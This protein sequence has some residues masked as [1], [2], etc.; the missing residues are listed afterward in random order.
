MS[1][2]WDI[3][4]TLAGHVPA[5][6]RDI[7]DISLKE[8]PNVPLGGSLEGRSRLGHDLRTKSL[9]AWRAQRA[10]KLALDNLSKREVTSPEVAR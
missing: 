3:S 6:D 7:W 4:G 8:C 5:Q 10:S 2:T 1:G 9:T